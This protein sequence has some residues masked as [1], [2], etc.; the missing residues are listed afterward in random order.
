MA[1][2]STAGGQAPPAN[3]VVAAE[4]QQP[5]AHQQL[6]PAQKHELAQ[7]VTALLRLALRIERERQG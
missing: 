7:K 3:P 4:R 1:T 2:Q 5:H 6:S